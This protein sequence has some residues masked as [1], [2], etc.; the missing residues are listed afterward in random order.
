MK[1]LILGSSGQIGF[2]LVS[3]LKSV[4]EEVIEFDIVE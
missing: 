1:H 3:Y 2:H 4:G